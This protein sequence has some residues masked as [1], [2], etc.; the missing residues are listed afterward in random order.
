MNPRVGIIGVGQTR[1]EPDKRKQN[2]TEII[3]EAACD[4]DEFAGAMFDK[5][6]YLLGLGIINALNFL[7]FERIAVGGGL[8]ESGNLIFEPARRALS[9]RG[10]SSYNYLV[11]IVPAAVPDE[12]GILGAVKMVVDMDV[13]S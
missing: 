4:G 13:D 10:F 8:A 2:L 1:Y 11:S 5:A 7:N 6:G 9:E 3:F 12:A